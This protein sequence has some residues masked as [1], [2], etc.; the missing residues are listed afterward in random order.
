[1]GKGEKIRRSAAG[2]LGLGCVGFSGFGLWGYAYYDSI[3]QSGPVDLAGACALAA[4]GAA[5]LGRKAF[6]WAFWPTRRV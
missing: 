1:M 4:F 6:K 3:P 2:L 5:W